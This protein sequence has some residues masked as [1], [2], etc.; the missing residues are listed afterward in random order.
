MNN[1]SIFYYI[2]NGI[3]S[4]SFIS[5]TTELGKIQYDALTKICK[6]TVL[7]INSFN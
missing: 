5:N 3:K 4:Y 7:T 6:L 2:K 1:K